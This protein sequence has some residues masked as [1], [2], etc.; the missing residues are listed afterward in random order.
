M[1]K[2][3]F[4]L[5]A[6]FISNFILAQNWSV[7]NSSDKFNYRLNDDNII[8]ATIWSDSNWV[9]GSDTVYFLNRIMCD[10]CATVTGGPNACDSSYGLKNQ[11]QFMQRKV[12]SS[13]NGIYNFRDDANIVINTLAA[14]NDSWTFDSTQTISATVIAIRTD[15]VFGN[16]DSIKT[17]LLSTSDTVTL[18][19]NYGILQYPYG[20]GRNSYYHLVGIEGRNLGE[21]VPGFNEIFNF[22][23]GDMFEYHGFSSYFGFYCGTFNDNV[24]NWIRKYS[25]VS[26]SQNGDTLIYGISGLQRV[27]CQE[28][29]NPFNPPPNTFYSVING[30]NIYT[31][32]QSNWLNRS[33]NRQPIKLENIYPL[34]SLPCGGND[35]AFD[36]IKTR[37]DSNFRFTKYFGLEN[38]DCQL[39]YFNCNY[40]FESEI[41]HHSDTLFLDQML[42]SY[43]EVA[44][45][46]LGITLYTQDGCFEGGISEVL[47]A[48]RKASD[49]IGSFTP[50]YFIS[51][52]NDLN[53]FPNS[54]LIYPNPVDEIVH[55]KLPYKTET[56]ITITDLQGKV[57]VTKDMFFET[58]FDVSQI[59]NGFYFITFKTREQIFTRNVLVIH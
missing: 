56:T 26:K 16:P 43:A 57:L 51:S 25:I 33:F 8:T 28:I 39:N 5:F 10:S 53:S 17:I 48:Y 9:S 46:G 55:V 29:N 14:L 11:P 36:F 47:T 18:S 44:V 37:I 20:Y 21:H 3:L 41:H 52:V 4:T 13:Q 54:V 24:E 59:E 35:S 45:V 34:S 50:D 6:F 49:T 27:I 22:D 58:N 40:F 15:S 12:I 30:F 1:K 7:I 19:K 31:D 32:S 42:W 23:V 2:I 38:P